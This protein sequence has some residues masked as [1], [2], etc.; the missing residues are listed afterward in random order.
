MLPIIEK[1]NTNQPSE[2]CCYPLLTFTTSV[3]ALV[4]FAAT[5]AA[6]T[7]AVAYAVACCLYFFLSLMYYHYWVWHNSLFQQ[8]DET[9]FFLSN[10]KGGIVEWEWDVYGQAGTWISWSQSAALGNDCCT[11]QAFYGSPVERLADVCCK[12][13]YLY[14]QQVHM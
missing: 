6:L 3:T 12:K 4:I 9:S 8:K 1:N 14:S 10:K 13:I 2:L 5:S 11:A 7:S